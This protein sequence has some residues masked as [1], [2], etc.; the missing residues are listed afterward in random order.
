[1]KY[2]QKGT[3]SAVPFSCFTVEFS[4]AIT[5]DEHGAHVLL[6]KKSY[7]KYSISFFVKSLDKRE[8]LCYNTCI[9]TED[10]EE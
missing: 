9:K 1:M 2:I 3:V 5:T 4:K 7:R 6:R 8:V 10:E